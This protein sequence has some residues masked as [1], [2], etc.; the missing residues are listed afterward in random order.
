[1]H[2]MTYEHAVK[3]AS[4]LI[5]LRQTEVYLRDD[6]GFP[7]DNVTSVEVG[8]TW[9]LSGPASIWVKAED[10]GLTFRMSV[11]FEGSD[12]NGRGVSLFNREHMR[13]IMRKLP[14]EGRRS[15]ARILAKQVL[16]P[17]QK[18]TAELREAMNAQAD[19]EDCVRG[20]ISFADEVTL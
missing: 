11:D 2:D 5:A 4:H 8:S 7:W 13:E 14:P 16:P 12:A 19:S 1:M 10:A 20:L 3:N 15:F 17:L 18:R 6:A 9:R